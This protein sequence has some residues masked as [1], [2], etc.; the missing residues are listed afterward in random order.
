MITLIALH[1][2]SNIKAQLCNGSLGDPVVDITFGSGAN[3]DYVPTGAYT[4]TSSSCPN[5]GFYTITNY[6]SGCFNNS[7]FTVTTD[8]TGGGAFMLVNAS[9]QPGDFFLTTVTNL[10]PNTNYQFSAWIMN[11]LNKFGIRPNL[12]FSIETPDSVVLGKYST[13]DIVETSQPAWKEYGLYFTTPANNAQVVLRIKNNAPG[14]NGNDIALD[15]ITF[16]PCG[17]KITA[18]IQGNQDTVN[19][20][21]GNTNVYTFTASV[22]S[23]FNVPVY[24]WQLSTDKGASWQ[25]IAGANT[26]SYMRLPSAVGSYWYRLA[27][28]EQISAS[29]LSCRVASNV[30]AVNVHTYPVVNAGPDRILIAGT[31]ITLQGSVTGELPIYYWS[32]PS[33]LDNDS[34]L[35]PAASP[36]ADFNY[37]LFAASPYGCKSN[38]AMQVKVVAGIFI[39]NAFT[40]NNDGKNDT[41]H[42]PFLDP[43]FGASVNVYNRYGQIVYH[44]EGSTVNWDGTCNNLPQPA[45][46]YVY[47]IRF[48]S[49]YPDMK[50]MIL[51]IR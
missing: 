44:V 7:W 21:D 47:S 41:W 38:D 22:S 5:D 49:G 40:P 19:V 13:G 48:R 3:T 45:G 23:G 6:T 50:G 27:V 34:I 10:C 4:Y 26:L 43:V 15:D 42:I 28:T 11:V 24:Q 39:P 35:T 14:G 33:Y 16:R 46:A 2:T 29:I 18:V 20:C 12:T 9:Y 30:V 1:F 25:D 36:P 8:H 51:L 31:P 17:P 37:T 32:P